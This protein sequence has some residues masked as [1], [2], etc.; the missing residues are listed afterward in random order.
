M[1]TLFKN[2]F[3]EIMIDRERKFAQVAYFEETQ[4]LTVEEYIENTTTTANYF[5]TFLNEGIDKILFDTRNNF[6][7]ISVDLQA[8]TVKQFEQFS[9]INYK[10]ATIL[11]T[12]LITMLS[13]E[14]AVD[15]FNDQNKRLNNS[16]FDNEEDAMEWLYS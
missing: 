2:R 8:W 3:L 5:K 15:G 10:S 11:S 4:N 14:Q 9:Q 16:F 6:Y 1:E 13:I 12:D 7:P